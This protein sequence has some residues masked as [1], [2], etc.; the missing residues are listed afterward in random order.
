MIRTLLDPETF[1][2]FCEQ[3]YLTNGRKFFWR[4]TRLT[5]FQ[6]LMVEFLLWKTRAENVEK[7]GRQLVISA[8]TP[9]ALLDIPRDTIRNHLKPLGLH[10]R[11]TRLLIKIASTL[12]EKYGGQVPQDA[13]ILLSIPGVGSYV[14][15]ATLL[16]AYGKPYVPL[17][18][19]VEKYLEKK[20]GSLRFSTRDRKY[21]LKQEYLKFSQR[22]FSRVKNPKHA[23]W[24]LLDKSRLGL[25]L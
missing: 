22:F 21:P 25:T 3:Y 1:G 10:N 15:V 11:R 6:V 19:N 7:Y 8:P 13:K 20:V 4:T 9:Q 16:F 24:G 12:V 17:D 14:A 2:T 18:A 23:A 5:P